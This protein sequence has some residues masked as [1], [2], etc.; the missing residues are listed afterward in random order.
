MTQRAGALTILVE[1]DDDYRFAEK[2]LVPVFSWK[3]GSRIHISQYAQMP[4]SGVNRLIRALKGQGEDYIL[5][6]DIDRHVCHP[7]RLHS[8]TRKYV[9]AEPKRIQIAIQAIE[10]WYYGGLSRSACDELGL[11]FSKLAGGTDRLQKQGVT[12]IRGSKCNLADRELL[13]ATLP[14]FSWRQAKA[15]NQSFRRFAL[16][17]APW[18]H[19]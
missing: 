15:Q 16:T 7:S 9:E 1:G 17:F 3:Y 2:V 11:R 10:S 8:L 6:A 14:H 12:A 18:H 13:I 5:L 4:P 19:G